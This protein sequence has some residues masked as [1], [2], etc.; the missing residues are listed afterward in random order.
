MAATRFYQI[1]NDHYG[2][3]ASHLSSAI[4]MDFQKSFLAVQ[5]LYFLNAVL[6]KCSLLYLYYRIFGVSRRFVI[7]LW[8]AMFLVVA[9]FVTCVVLSIAGCEP[10]SYFWDKNQEGGCINEVEFFKWNG[11]FNML[12]DVLV[13]CLPMPMLFKVQL[14]RR[15][16]VFTVGLFSLGA[17]YVFPPRINP[18]SSLT[19]LFLPTNISTPSVCVASILRILAFRKSNQADPTYTTIDTAAWSSVEQSLGI[20]C[21][22]LPTLGPLFGTRATE[23]KR[24]YAMTPSFDVQLDYFDDGEGGNG[25]RSQMTSRVDSGH[26]R[27]AESLTDFI[28][29][30]PSGKA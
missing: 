17:L 3:H 5:Q 1:V 30:G 29:A 23:K 4:V 27:S 22:C 26:N 24:T 9:Y 10:V 8:V 7:A 15:E 16:K 12:L 21:A 6:T 13:F 25:M 20:L 2:T 14:R 19:L 28:R 11:I 18:N